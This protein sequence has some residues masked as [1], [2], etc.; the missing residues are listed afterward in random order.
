M[1][2]I[3]PEWKQCNHIQKH[4]PRSPAFSNRHAKLPSNRRQQHCER[5]PFPPG[6]TSATGGTTCPRQLASNGVPPNNRASSA[7][8]MRTPLDFPVVPEV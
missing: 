2:S 1:P 6:A 4:R 3:H 5:P 7:H 8:D